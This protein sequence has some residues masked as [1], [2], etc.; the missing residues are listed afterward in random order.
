MTTYYQQPINLVVENSGL[1]KWWRYIETNNG[2]TLYVSPDLEA[3]IRDLIN[4]INIKSLDADVIVEYL[5]G[6][7]KLT[8]I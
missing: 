3:E 1:S 7:S 2:I 8:G 5:N 4:H 6:T